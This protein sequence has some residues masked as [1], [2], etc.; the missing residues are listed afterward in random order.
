MTA[1]RIAA[2]AA[3]SLAL[4]ACAS[5]A[6]A[7]KDDPAQAYFA[8]AVTCKAADAK[9]VD[10]AAIATAPA[11][12]AGQCV[13]VVGFASNDRLYRAAEFMLVD[14]TTRRHLELV[15]SSDGTRTGSLLAILD[16]GRLA[17][18]DG[19]SNGWIAQE[20]GNSAH[21]VRTWVAAFAALAAVGAYRVHSRYYRPVPELI[22]GFA[23][24]TAFPR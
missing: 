1:I 15:S 16:E 22:A 24:R 17:E 3:I 9:P 5:M 14:D 19:W 21:E 11:R 2:V 8:Q 18:L 6:P 20:G 13:N 10:L 23:V 12:Y 4:A 7:P